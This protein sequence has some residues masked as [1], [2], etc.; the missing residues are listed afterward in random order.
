MVLGR[1]EQ[2]AQVLESLVEG[3][4]Q[5]ILGHIQSCGRDIHEIAHPGGEQIRLDVV[6]G[7]KGGLRVGGCSLLT[8]RAVALPSEAPA[9]CPRPLPGPGRGS[10]APHMLQKSLQLL[11]RSLRRDHSH[12]GGLEVRALHPGHGVDRQVGGP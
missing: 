11:Q 5:V 10:G 7:G 6:R 1:R 12:P 8:A 9:R 2:R 4:S 3:P